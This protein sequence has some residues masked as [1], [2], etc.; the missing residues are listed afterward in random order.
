MVNMKTAALSAL[1]GLGIGTPAAHALRANQKSVFDPVEYNAVYDLKCLYGDTDHDGKLTEQEYS[2]F[3]VHSL[4]SDRLDSGFVFL[5]FNPIDEHRMCFY[6]YSLSDIRNV[7]GKDFAY[8]FSYR[9]SPDLSSD[10]NGYLNDAVKSSDASFVNAYADG[11]GWFCKF[12]VSGYVPVSREGKMRIEA[13]S[14]LASAGGKNVLDE[15]ISSG[16]ATELLYSGY[17]YSSSG[18]LFS[19][20]VYK[21]SGAVDMMLASARQITDTTSRLFF[22]PISSASYVEEAKEIPYFF[23]NFEDSEFSPDE[24]KSISY[25]CYYYTFTNFTRFVE[26]HN[27]T[28][29]SVPLHGWKSVFSGR[30]NDPTGEYIN[31]CDLDDSDPEHHFRAS[32]SDNLV[33]SR[34]FL[35]GK[36]NGETVYVTQTDTL[37]GWFDHS[38]VVRKYRLPTIVN[39]STVDSDFS[40]DDAEAKPFLDFINAGDH[41]QYRWAY[42]LQSEAWTRSIV[43]K[44]KIGNQWFQK[45]ERYDWLTNRTGARSADWDVF[46]EKTVCH[47]PVDNSIVTLSMR[48]RKQSEA[49]DIR[50]MNNPES[51]RKI[52]M[53]GLPAPKISDFIR[54]DL[55]NLFPDIPDW[56]PWVLAAIALLIVLLIIPKAWRGIAF[57]FRG[58]GYVFKAAINLLY[59]AFVWWWLAIIRRIEAAEQPPLWIWRK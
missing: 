44:T 32:S 22:I 8:Q 53:V 11:K 54:N 47:Q 13:V 28:E 37:H 30:L 33:S 48:V 4:I 5:G 41:R 27:D 59:I 55:R 9:N 56:V 49:Y 20:K 15:D 52:Y 26:R 18:T 14:F 57:V 1:L 51:V 31:I 29:S 38:A 12:L 58:I 40:A 39:M 24:I 3:D 19:D 43:S 17:G 25:N 50:V 46:E 10:G 6:T 2:S 34:D 35:S 36:V 23:F 16:E 7:G 42:A 45:S 21:I